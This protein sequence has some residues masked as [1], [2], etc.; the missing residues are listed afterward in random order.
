VYDRSIYDS[1]ALYKRGILAY[2]TAMAVRWNVRPAMDKAG[3]K[4]AYQLAEA[5]GLKYPI[6]WRVCSGEPVDR[7]NVST[8]EAIAAAL[9]VKDPLTLLEYRK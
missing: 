3:I 5:T 4:N 2:R 6:C 7:V 1:R 8:L 9:N